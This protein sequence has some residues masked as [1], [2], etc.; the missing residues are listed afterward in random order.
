MQ[1]VDK[2]PSLTGE[3]GSAGS[4][5]KGRPQTQ[6]TRAKLQRPRPRARAR[7]GGAGEVRAHARG[8]ASW[9]GGGAG[10][11]AGA[12]T[13]GARVAPAAQEQ[14]VPP[15]AA[16]GRTGSGAGG[17]PRH[18][19]GADAAAAAAASHRRTMSGQLERCEREWH[20]LEGEFQELQVGPGHLVAQLC[21]LRCGAFPF[22]PTQ[23]GRW[24]PSRGLPMAGHWGL[25]V[26]VG[27]HPPI[28]QHFSSSSTWGARWKLPITPPS[29]RLFAPR[30]SF[31]AESW[32]VASEGNFQVCHVGEA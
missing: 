14:L 27:Q 24:G 4:F 2:L 30:T 15:K 3:T 10:A 1:L 19:A 8:P 17:R 26:R 25:V 29:H 28:S 9:R 31:S 7:G 22:L 21:Y 13:S 18:A 16:R 23:P 5:S 32:S 12:V 11:G 20:E 6:P